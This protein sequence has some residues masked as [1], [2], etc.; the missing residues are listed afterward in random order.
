MNRFQTAAADATV[1]TA[2]HLA[3]VA[4]NDG[5]IV[6]CPALP[7]ASGLASGIDTWALAIATIESVGWELQHW[8]ID[9]SGNARPVFRKVEV[10]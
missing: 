3:A 9:P 7:K 4:R 8:A 6:Y 5:A 10:R 2:Y 1:E